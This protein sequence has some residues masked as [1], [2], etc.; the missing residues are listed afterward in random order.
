[1]SEDYEHL[2]EPV[3]QEISQQYD[4]LELLYHETCEKMK[5]DIREIFSDNRKFIDFE[6]DLD[7]MK[8]LCQQQYFRE[9]NFWITMGHGLRSHTM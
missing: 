1:M 7:K 9:K 3:I 2:I 4:N 5:D 6:K 8:S